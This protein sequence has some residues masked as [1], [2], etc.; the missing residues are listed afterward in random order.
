MAFSDAPQRYAPRR[1]AA[2]KHH[3]LPR[4]W[5]EDGFL[6]FRLEVL[7]PVFI[8]SGENFSPLEYVIRKESGSYAMYLVDSI[9]WLTAE[10]TNTAVKKALEEGEMLRLRRVM[11]DSLD[12]AVYGRARLSV[13]DEIAEKLLNYIQNTESNSKAE[14]ASFVRTPLSNTAIVPGSSLKGAISTPIIDDLDRILTERSQENLRDAYQKDRIGGY[15]STLKKMFGNIG[16]HAMQALKVADIALP[17]AGTRIAAACEMRLDS[18][19]R[20]TPKPPCEILPPS[21]CGGLPLYGNIR[22]DCSSGQPGIRLPGGALLTWKKIVELCNDFYRRRFQDEWGKFYTQRHFAQT[23]EAL[24]QVKE[25]IEKLDPE[26]ELLLRV[27]H[28]A[29][30]ECVTVEHNKP[31]SKKGYGNTRTLADGQLPFG[32]VIL[33]RCT[34]K[35]FRAG[36]QAVEQEILAARRQW[37][38]KRSDH[39]AFLQKAMEQQRQKAEAAERIRKQEEAK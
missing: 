23:R 27:G 30:I 20:G 33:Q 13:P 38:Q 5:T 2:Q 10:Q 26:K 15:R 11:A 28:Y 21:S 14:I 24:Q 32:W 25:R 36:V 16:E 6:P 17:A 9:A 12:V 29:H 7:T 35:E 1:E 37:E 19:K 18:G 34:E 31:E 8:G 4:R 22:L 3:G 39:R